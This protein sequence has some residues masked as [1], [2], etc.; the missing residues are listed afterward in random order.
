MRG[1]RADA[2][3]GCS[4][5]FSMQH[6]PTVLFSFQLLLVGMNRTY[7]TLCDVTKWDANLHVQCTFHCGNESV[8]DAQLMRRWYGIHCWDLAMP[9]IWRHLR[10]SRCLGRP[11]Y[12]KITYDRANGPRWGPQSE[13]EWVTAVKRLRG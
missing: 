9:Q 12:I 11:E 1:S 5:A 4:A 8:V 2:A 7:G 6:F 10:C 3:E 13:R